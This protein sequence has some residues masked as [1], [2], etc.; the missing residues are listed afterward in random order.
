MHIYGEQ[1]GEP[2]QNDFLALNKGA[3]VHLA[4]DRCKDR[5]NN[6]ADLDPVEEKAHDENNNHHENQHFPTRV[7]AQ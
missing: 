2:G 6:Q 1:D 3:E 7:N 5:N 4:H